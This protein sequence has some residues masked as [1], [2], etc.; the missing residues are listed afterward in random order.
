MPLATADLAGYINISLCKNLQ[1]NSKVLNSYRVRRVKVYSALLWLKEH[2]PLY[3]DIFID[4]SAVDS[5]PIDGIPNSIIHIL[6][7]DNILEQDIPMGQECRTDIHNTGLVENVHVVSKEDVAA[8]MIHKYL[9]IKS[10]SYLPEWMPDLF[11]KTFPWLFPDGCNAPNFKSRQKNG[12]S[13][14]SHIKWLLNYKDRRFSHDPAFLFFTLNAQQ[15]SNVLSLTRFCFR[16]SHSAN[17]KIS[18]VTGDQIRDAITQLNNKNLVTDPAVLALMKRLKIISSHAKG[19]TAARLSMRSKIQSMNYI[20]GCPAIFLTINPCDIHSS[21]AMAFAGQTFD[22]IT[23]SGFPCRTERDKILGSDPVTCAKFCHFIFEST[24]QYLLGFFPEDHKFYQKGLGVFGKPLAYAGTIEEQGR[25][26]LHMHLLLWLDGF[27]LEKLQEQLSTDNDFKKRLIVYLNSIISEYCDGV[28]FHD[29]ENASRFSSTSP[30]CSSPSHIEIDDSHSI[31]PKMR[32]CVEWINHEGHEDRHDLHKEK[33]STCSLSSYDPDCM[34]YDALNAYDIQTLVIDSQ[35]HVHN[36]TCTKNHQS[37]CRM[38]FGK[39]IEISTLVDD[40]GNIRLKRL[41]PYMNAFNET[42]LSLLRCNMD[43]KFIASASYAKTL[44]YYITNYITKM[45]MPFTT[46]YELCSVA[47]DKINSK[48]IH[49]SLDPHEKAKRLV[50]A[51]F[52][53]MKTAEEIGAPMAA[54]L[55]LGLPDFHCSE[56]FVT[57]DF[58]HFYYY[59]SSFSCQEGSNDDLLDEIEIHDNTAIRV[60]GLSDYLFRNESLRHVSVLDFFMQYYKSACACVQT[61]TGL[62]FL[63]L[64]PQSQTHVIRKRRHPAIP[65]FTGKALPIYKEKNDFAYAMMVLIFPFSAASPLNPPENMSWEEYL[66]SYQASSLCS[67]FKAK[68]VKNIILYQQGSNSDPPD[69]EMGDLLTK[70]FQDITETGDTSM[71]AING[72]DPMEHIDNDDYLDLFNNSS[73]E[74]DIPMNTQFSNLL[75]PEWPSATLHVSRILKVQQST[76]YRHQLINSTISTVNSNQSTN[77]QNPCVQVKDL[78][79]TISTIKDFVNNLGLLGRQRLIVSSFLLFCITSDITT[80]LSKKNVVGVVL[81]EGGTGKSE[82]I[83]SIYSYFK[84]INQSNAIQLT[85]PTGVAAA[86]IL[87]V[88][89]HSLLSLMS[90]NPNYNDLAEKLEGVK[91]F[92]IDEFAMLGL[93]TLNQI[94]STLRMVWPINHHRHS[95]PFGGYHMLFTGDFMQLPPVKSRALYASLNTIQNLATTTLSRRTNYL[96]G[97]NSWSSINFAIVLR[98]NYRTQ[99]ILYQ[100]VLRAIRTESFT[101]EHYM[102]LK[103]RFDCGDSDIPV[104]ASYICRTNEKR[105]KINDYYM[106]SLSNLSSSP[107][108]NMFAQD[109]LIHRRQKIALSADEQLHLRTL[110]DSPS[111]YPGCLKLTPGVQVMILENIYPD[112]CIMNGSLGTVVK[113]SH[114]PHVNSLKNAYVVVQFD[115]LLESNISFDEHLPKGCVVFQPSK[116]KFRYNNKYY[117]RT[118]FPMCIAKAISVHKSQSKTLHDGMVLCYD[119]QMTLPMLYVALSR[120]RSLSDLFIHGSIP[121]EAFQKSWPT[122][123]KVQLKAILNLQKDTLQYALHYFPSLCDADAALL[124]YEHSLD[125]EEMSMLLNK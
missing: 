54:L 18:D 118:Q 83:K 108:F 116:C 68:F 75:L 29:P 120:V 13:F 122:E 65:Q 40:M 50:L 61:T 107:I 69:S 11:A 48:E 106:N 114:Q 93:D 70:D 25:K 67:P 74:C 36:K 3:K 10:E 98:K 79:L 39:K 16:N 2:N 101:D 87:G 9:H 82:V 7:N 53:K 62:T 123:L 104:N 60:N 38:R 90:K 30:T 121:L 6:P 78:S 14:A 115:W 119:K 88:T 1:D 63:P 124:N 58:T 55:Q 117:E 49:N 8:K 43:V 109:I 19:S 59:I 96:N 73:A 72:I 94:D 66:E 64:H 110:P 100:N 47:V 21:L 33:Y 41:H 125:L 86:N 95:M 92:I 31:Y 57:L 102:I 32:T 77:L 15:K 111:L 80:D 37:H 103:T 12:L 81:G 51:C 52:S 22:P 85:C 34:N 4:M 91:V 20:Y 56:D 99:H 76:S 112:L 113:I 28:F 5:L 27:D 26:A 42:L 46:M 105:A 89:I 17:L 84:S 45:N 24:I 97:L 23:L 44:N 35:I 71:S